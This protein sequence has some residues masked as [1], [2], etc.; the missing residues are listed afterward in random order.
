MRARSGAQAPVV[1]LDNPMLYSGLVLAHTEDAQTDQ[2]TDDGRLTAYEVS[3]WDLRGT[4]LVTLSACETGLGELGLGEGVFGL[5]R[6]FVLADAQTQVMSLWNISDQ[7]TP[8]VMESFYRRLTKGEGRSEAMQNAQLAMLRSKDHSHPYYWAAFVA[9]GEWRP[10]SLPGEPE[11]P[12][13]SRRGCR[14]S[15]GDPDDHEHALLLLLAL[16]HRRR[17]R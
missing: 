3:G 5:R 2:P 17:R 8:E 10:L 14:A 9:S 4:Q 15:V 11:P 12:P 13:V 16:V 1:R 7:A 6:T